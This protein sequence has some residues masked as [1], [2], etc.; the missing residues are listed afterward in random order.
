M[1]LPLSFN[2]VEEETFF[3]IFIVTAADV[4]RDVVGVERVGVF[5]AALLL[6]LLIELVLVFLLRLNL[7]L[8]HFVLLPAEFYAFLAHVRGRDSKAITT[9]QQLR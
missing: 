6:L 4:L 7:E 2:V 9:L 8:V 3:H 5:I 1:S